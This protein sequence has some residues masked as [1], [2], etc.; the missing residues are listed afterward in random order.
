MADHPD[1]VRSD[2]PPWPGRPIA[3]GPGAESTGRVSPAPAARSGCATDTGRR[4]GATVPISDGPK[5]QR[6]ARGWLPSVASSTRWLRA[7]RL[8]SGSPSPGVGL[9]SGRIVAGQ[10]SAVK[11]PQRYGACAIAKGMRPAAEAAC[12]AQAP[13]RPRN[14]PRPQDGRRLVSRTARRRFSA[15]PRPLP[16]CRRAGAH[17]PVPE[18]QKRRRSA[19]GAWA[20]PPLPTPQKAAKGQLAA[21]NMLRLAERFGAAPRA[22]GGRAARS[23]PAAV[24]AVNGPAFGAGACHVIDQE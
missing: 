5:R 4:I 20:A 8:R 22:Q 10:S 15:P 12:P 17:Q 6:A 11:F 1:M 16:M 24:P 14:Q 18:R 21:K 9:P 7:E 13:D 3:Q 19:E 23:R 2:A